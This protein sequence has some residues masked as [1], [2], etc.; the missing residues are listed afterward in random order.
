MQVSNSGCFTFHRT[1]KHCHYSVTAIISA[2]IRAD[3]VTVKGTVDCGGYPQ[4]DLIFSGAV[5]R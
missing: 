4:P 3:C 1:V 5:G 2:A